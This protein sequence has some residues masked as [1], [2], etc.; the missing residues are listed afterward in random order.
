M[1]V[2]DLYGD[3][4]STCTQ[5]VL[6]LLEELQ[7]KYNLNKIDV[8][9]NENKTSEFITLQ[10]FGKIPTM[11]YDDRIVFESRSMLRYISRNNVDIKDLYSGTDVDIW[12]EVEAQ[13]FYPPAN[14]IVYE[15]M[16]KKWYGKKA[17]IEIVNKNL[18][19]LD[20]VL[21]V[22][23]QRLSRVSF[24]AGEEFTIADISHIP[25][26]N[27][28]LKCGYKQVFKKYTNVYRW[29]KKIIKRESVQYILSEEFNRDINTVNNTSK[30]KEQEIEKVELINTIQEM[31]IKADSKVE[32][33]KKKY[34]SE[35]QKRSVKKCYSETSSSEQSKSEKDNSIKKN[36]KE[37]YS[38]TS[39]YEKTKSHRNKKV[40]NKDHSERKSRNVDKKSKEIYNQKLKLKL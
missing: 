34:E 28:L 9:K 26:I 11:K 22:Y 30:D 27:Y 7:L 15:K 23:D 36:I 40:N 35:K 13:N 38:E 1:V 29:I 37:K 20:K 39:S 32:S 21:N 10:P 14:A 16:F 33:N 25:Y 6:I 5:R 8:L 4:R 2:V 24:I 12:L 19:E 17:D 3:S 31:S 18:E